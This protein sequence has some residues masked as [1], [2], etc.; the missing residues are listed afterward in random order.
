MLL[1]SRRISLQSITEI[2][3]GKDDKAKRCLQE[4]LDRQ[5]YSE[6]SLEHTM[7]AFLQTFRLAGVES[8]VV[9]NILERFGDTYF[10]RDPTKLFPSGE[11]A[12]NFAYL[13]IVL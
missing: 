9:F 2:I 7:R 5:D 13:I 1:S 11:E 3:G 8:Q 6:G 12:Y 10:E 4:Y